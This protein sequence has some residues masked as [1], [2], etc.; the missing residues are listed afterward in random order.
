M[1]KLTIIAL[2]LM[3]TISTASAELG[4]RVGAGLEI[5]TFDV[6]GKEV[7]PTGTTK[8]KTGDSEAFVGMGTFFVEKQLGFLPGFLERLSIGYSYVPHDIKSG[9]QDRATTDRV[10]DDKD[11]NVTQKVQADLQ[12]ISTL[13]VTANITDWLFVKAGTT[14]MDI[15]TNEKLPTGSQYGN[16]SIDGTIL[17]IGL[18][19]TTD[20]GLFMRLEMQETSFGGITL[21]STTNSDNKITLDDMDG[22]TYRVSVGKAF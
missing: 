10:S 13:Y 17:G 5:G 4:L 6:T 16:A 12:D 2:F 7:T 8:T 15:V 20:N 19:H 11:D 3:G 21:T 14:D 22:T 1:R 18:H 9:T